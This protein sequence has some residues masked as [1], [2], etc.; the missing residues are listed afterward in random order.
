VADLTA[1]VGDTVRTERGRILGGLLRLYGSLDAAEEA[2]Q[3]AALAALQAWRDQVPS[4]P[5]AWLMT[6]ARNSAQDARRRR[7][8]AEA[9]APL[10]VE[11]DVDSPDTVDTV[12]DDYLRLIFTCCHP[13]LS[14]DNQIALTLKVVAGFS[15]E[16]IARAFVCSEATV[17]QRILRARQT[18]VEKRIGY[19]IPERD[20][21]AGR[22]SAVLGVVYAMFNEGHTGQSGPLM[23]LD[24]Q[25]EALRLTRMLC[26]LLPRE[27]EAFGALAII[28]FG[29]ARAHTRVDEEGL[30]VLLAAQDRSR[31]NQ[32]LVREGLMALRRALA[33][34][35]GPVRLAGGARGGARD[36]PDVGEHRLGEDRRHVRRARGGLAVADRRPEPSHRHLDACWTFR[37][38]RVPHGARAT[39]RE[40]P[41]FLRGARGHARA[42]RRRSAAGPG[43]SAL[44]RDERGR[45]EIDRAAAPGSA[46]AHA[47][48][49][50]GSSTERGAGFLWVSRAPGSIVM[51][52]RA[53]RR[54]VARATLTVRI[55]PKARES[56]GTR[57]PTGRPIIWIMVT[58]R[59]PG[60]PTGRR[61][62]LRSLAACVVWNS[63][64]GRPRRRPFPL[65]HA[66]VRR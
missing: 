39:A 5:G 18:L 59:G 10:L 33:R 61:P 20:D 41:P 11:D 16:E 26:D 56:Q 37:G 9:K 7:S 63:L 45:A 2:F 42:L 30:P 57:G 49:L 60:G 13:E 35:K 65:R 50:T 17:A 51:A 12:S 23:R 38:P 25:A 54:L 32:E 31:W 8:L 46:R 44:S 40:V 43:E 48:T 4:N 22:V 28:A 36:G 24:L 3:E 15:T 66:S 6:A 19:A 53:S 34:G 58:R 64:T 47:P 27:P 29:A 62:R 21:L 52:V 14:I 55:A 1:I